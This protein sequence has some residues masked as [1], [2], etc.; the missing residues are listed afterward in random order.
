MSEKQEIWRTIAENPNYEVSNLGHVRHKERPNQYLKPMPGKNT[1]IKLSKD[2]VVSFY[3]IPK[4]VFSTFTGITL[5]KG[6]WVNH[7][8][9][10]NGNNCLENLQ[11]GAGKF[12]R[13][14]KVRCVND[15]KIFNRAVEAAE[16]YHISNK[17]KVTNVCLHRTKQ[18][19]GYVFE[20]V[21]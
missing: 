16:Y 18:C 17:G 7:V 21:D 6:E 15:G 9:G 1:T 12:P 8:D 20:Y 3:N 11:F 5:P 10:N 13:A 19:Q 2:G 14:K 4:L